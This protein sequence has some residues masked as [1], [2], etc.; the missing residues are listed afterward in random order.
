MRGP[1]SKAAGLPAS[2]MHVVFCLTCLIF[3]QIGPQ[4]V[5][6][7]IGWLDDG[8]DDGGPY[9]VSFFRIQQ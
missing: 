3:F 5:T 4:C 7:W 9:V 2:C 8:G 1:G 6:H